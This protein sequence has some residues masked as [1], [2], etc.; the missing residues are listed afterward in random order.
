MS[1]FAITSFA[2]IIAIVLI[3]G[4]TLMPIAAEAAKMSKAEKVAV[5]QATVACKGEA[6]GRKIGWFARRKF[7]NTCVARALKGYPGMSPLQLSRQ[8]PNMKR[9]PVLQPSE[10]GCPS[11]GRGEC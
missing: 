5:K 9:L 7:V 10:W 1:R 6:K 4:T 3:G 8:H 11:S 2:G